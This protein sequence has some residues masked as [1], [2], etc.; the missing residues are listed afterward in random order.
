[1]PFLP[2]F[3][4]FMRLLDGHVT[5]AIMAPIVAFGGWVPMLLNLGSRGT[6]A[7]NLPNVVGIIQMVAAVGILVTV[8]VSLRILPKRPEKY[9]S[10]RTLMMVLQW[11]LSPVI[12]IVYQSAAAFYAQTRLMV[13]NY[14]EKFD[15]TKKVV[16]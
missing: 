10:K 7:F 11:V 3:I 14:M 9:N 5:L 15:V 8:F 4:K 1:M 12:A 16:K 6:V 2:L 13:G